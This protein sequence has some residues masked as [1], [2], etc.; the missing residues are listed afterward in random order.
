[1]KVKIFYSFIL[2]LGLSCNTSEKSGNLSKEVL[3][4]VDNE[5]YFFQLSRS[6][7]PNIKANSEGPSRFEVRGYTCTEIFNS[8]QSI[9]EIEPALSD[10]VH[11]A[12]VYDVLMYTHDGSEVPYE[13]LIAELANAWLLKLRKE[14]IN[15]KVIMLSVAQPVNPESLTERNKLTLENSMLTLENPSLGFLAEKLTEQ[16]VNHFSTNQD[17]LFIKGK[18]QINLKEPL[19]VKEALS[20]S[21]ILIDTITVNRLKYTFE[22]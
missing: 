7:N 19:S 4:H 10:S 13:K 5:A 15:R 14:E 18:I 17:S 2:L 20:G 8:I 22:K 6:G 11:L 16:L 12:G 9:A 21:K 3:R 1:M